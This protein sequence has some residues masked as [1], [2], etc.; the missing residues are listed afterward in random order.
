MNDI[1][2]AK[3]SEGTIVDYL[4]RAAQ[5]FGDDYE[6]IKRRMGELNCHYDDTGQ[7]VNGRD[8]WLWIFISNEVVL[9]NTSKSRSKTVLMEILGKDYYKVTVQDF[10]PFCDGAPGLKQK[11]WSHLIRDARDLA[12]KK[13]PPPFAKEFH[14]GLQQ[15]FKDAKEPEKLLRSEEDRCREFEC[16]CG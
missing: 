7:R 6:R 1:Y 3:V 8:R 10:Y 9:Y 11:C 4:K 13:K 5:I 15:I 16:M 14:E 12:E 2:D